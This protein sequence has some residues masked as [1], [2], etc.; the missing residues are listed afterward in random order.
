MQLTE[1]DQISV[2]TPSHFRVKC[3]SHLIARCAESSANYEQWKI[4]WNVCELHSDATVRHRHKT[5]IK[6]RSSASH[7]SDIKRIQ[8]ADEQM[9]GKWTSARTRMCFWNS[10]R[11]IAFYPINWPKR[12]EK[13]FSDA[14]CLGIVHWPVQSEKDEGRA[15]IENILKCSK[16]HETFTN[17][18]IV[19]VLNFLFVVAV[20]VDKLLFK[21]KNLQKRPIQQLASRRF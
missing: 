12:F 21:L 17:D 5:H 1:S 16:S 7:S 13:S 19:F 3:I 14:E 9:Q 11:C 20:F 10:I 8:I 18:L 6:W 4:I 2:T 15:S